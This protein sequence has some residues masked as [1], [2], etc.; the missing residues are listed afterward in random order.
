MIQLS[1]DQQLA[2]DAVFDWWKK[3]SKLL[4]LAGFA[5][6]GKTTTVREIIERIR[7]K[8]EK[9]V[10]V[11]YC[12]F[13]GRAS[14]ILASKIDLQD[15]DTCST[16]HALIYQPVVKDG[17]IRGWKR[18][19]KL[20]ADLLVVDEASMV[21]KFIFADLEK[22]G[23]PILA[24][25]DHGQLPPVNG[26]F[27]LM[28]K[29]DI[30]LEKIHRQAEGNPIIGVSMIA[31]K[32]GKIPI[33]DYGQG[34]EKRSYKS[35]FQVLDETFDPNAVYLCAFNTTRCILNRFY[36]QKMRVKASEPIKGEKVI[37]LKNNREAGIF[38]GMTGV[39]EEIAAEGRE[40]YKVKIKMDGGAT[41]DGYISRFQFG[42][43][44]VPKFWDTKE[45]GDLFDW[46][47]AM[48]T[49]K[50]QGSQARKV[51][52]IEE[53]GR[54]DDDYHAKWLYT[55]ATRAQEELLILEQRS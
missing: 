54:W 53:R 27:N 29:P 46:G 55:S 2:S 51:I 10:R 34:V 49:H 36:R 38:N 47:Y 14:Q 9:R 15:G 40:L 37:C 52:L 31:R 18:V 33:G 16:I 28:E 4:R 41:Y 5:G 30:R 6:T 20:D 21:D 42:Q 44:E 48:T 22:F 17:R 35:L 13:T 7:K 32:Q 50:A 45:M 1:E 23:I 12:A 39:I 43:R 19:D 25:G 26:D 8:S 11:S 24:V 3:G